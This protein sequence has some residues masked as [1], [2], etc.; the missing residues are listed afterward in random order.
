MSQYYDI[1][2]Y[3][4]ICIYVHIYIHT[5]TCAEDLGRAAAERKKRFFPKITA[6]LI[7]EIKSSFFS[8]FLVNGY[9]LSCKCQKCKKK[10]ILLY[11]YGIF[12]LKII[13]KYLPVG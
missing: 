9:I 4:Y 3:M 12:I 10:I 7:F 6:R 2:V 5:Y 13:S 8:P 1:Y 11:I